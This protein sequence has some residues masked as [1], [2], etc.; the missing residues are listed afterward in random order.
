LTAV[1]PGFFS[2][3]AS[4]LLDLNSI[5]TQFAMNISDSDEELYNERTAL[6]PSENPAV[7]SYRPDSDHSPTEDSHI[8]T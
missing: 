6:V 8:K 7:P 4:D 5:Q 2:V 3:F 1:F